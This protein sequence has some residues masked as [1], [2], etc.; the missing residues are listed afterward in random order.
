MGYQGIA[1]KDVLD[2]LADVK[3]RFNIDEDRTYLTGY[4]MGGGGTLWI[5]LTRPDVW[6]AL[7]PYVPRLHRVPTS[8]RPT[9]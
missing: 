7:A 2:V 1:E 6:A 8:S 9:D 4:S 5:G 3:K